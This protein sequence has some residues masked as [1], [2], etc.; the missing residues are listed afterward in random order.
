M[1]RCTCTR[2]NGQQIGCRPFCVSFGLLLF[3]ELFYSYDGACGQYRS[4]FHGSRKTASVVGGPALCHTL[5]VVNAVIHNIVRRH[6]QIGTLVSR[7]RQ[8][9]RVSGISSI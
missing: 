3:A 1:G 5:A 6:F 9:E 8:N 4:E 2:V 7:S